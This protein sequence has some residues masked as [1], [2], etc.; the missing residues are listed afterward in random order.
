MPGEPVE[1]LIGTAG[2]GIG[3]LVVYAVYKNVSPLTL[4]REAISTGKFPDISKLPKLFEDKGVG[5]T[6]PE[7][8]ARAAD[9][10]KKD[11]ELGKRMSAAIDAWI[12]NP[13]KDNEN[14]LRALCKEARK[15][16]FTKEAN[17]IEAWIFLEGPKGGGTPG[18][19]VAV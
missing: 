18:T 11:P 6:T 3:V 13:T 9:I 7:P 1:T 16:G 19:P 10:A 8:N 14:K 5:G 15:K 12:K 2:I 17:D 4:L